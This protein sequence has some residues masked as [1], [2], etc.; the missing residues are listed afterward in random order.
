MKIQAITFASKNPMAF[1]GVKQNSAK[2][3]KLEMVQPAQQLKSVSSA[4]ILSQLGNVSFKGDYGRDDL[5]AYE[6]YDGPLPPDIEVEKYKRS[7]KVQEAIDEGRYLDAIQGKISLA[8]IVRRQGKERDA[9][10]LE[11]SIR[12][13]YKCLPLSQK[14]QARNIISTYNIDMAAHIDEDITANY[15]RFY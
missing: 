2:N 11:T 4:V 14:A 8:R 15:R 9:F 13:L 1:E 6:N 3:S 12:E 7:V 5:S 10:L